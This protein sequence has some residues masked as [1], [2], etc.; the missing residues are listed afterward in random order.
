MWRSRAISSSVACRVARRA[1]DAFEG[2][3]H[4]DHFDNFALALAHDVDAAAR[5]HAQKNFLLE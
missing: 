2:R 3:P 5:H 1:A 4:L